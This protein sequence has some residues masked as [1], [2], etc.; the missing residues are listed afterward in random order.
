MFVSLLFYG[1]HEM[2]CGNKCMKWYTFSQISLT[3][4]QPI[5]S[6]ISYTTYQ[7][8]VT[9]VK[10]TNMARIGF[11]SNVNNEMYN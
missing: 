10:K 3:V 4:N 11:T 1:A 8:R 5:F 9:K 2:K 6:F 7:V